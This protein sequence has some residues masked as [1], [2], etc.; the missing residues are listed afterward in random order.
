[1]FRFALQDMW[2]HKSHQPL[3]S[4]GLGSDC[5]LPSLLGGVYPSPY[6]LPWGSGP[7]GRGWESARFPIFFASEWFS[8]WHRFFDAFLTL[9]FH[10]LDAKMGLKSLH[11]ES[12][13]RRNFNC[14][15]AAQLHLRDKC[16]N[17]TTPTRKPHSCIFSPSENFTKTVQKPFQEA[18]KI[19]IVLQKDLEPQKSRFSC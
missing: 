2:L 8:F 5:C 4:G 6:P 15:R 16:K 17:C 13:G 12:P 1:M 19:D 10:G 18:F 3:G 11:F 7:P 9:I 14:F